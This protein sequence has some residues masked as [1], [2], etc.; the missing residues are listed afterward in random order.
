MTA[1][2]AQT[3]LRLLAG[4]PICKQLKL[5]NLMS[6]MPAPVRAAAAA[7]LEEGRR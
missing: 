5:A 2:G 6:R 4:E 1:D 3:L 7:L